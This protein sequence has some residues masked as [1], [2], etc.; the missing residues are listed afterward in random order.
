MPF[1]NAIVPAVI[2][3]DTMKWED[4]PNVHH[5]GNIVTL[6][7]SLGPHMLLKETH[8]NRLVLVPAVLLSKYDVGPYKDPNYK[9]PPTE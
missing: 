4:P 8:T 1:D 7:Y 5:T 3:K 9:A 2:I 6:P